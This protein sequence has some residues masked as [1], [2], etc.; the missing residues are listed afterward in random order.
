MTV[1]FKTVFTIEADDVLSYANYWQHYSLY[2]DR[3]DYTQHNYTCASLSIY[4][5]NHVIVFLIKAL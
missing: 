5:N 4:L 2:T 1:L 3:S